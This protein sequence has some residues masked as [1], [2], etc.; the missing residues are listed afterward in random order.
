[1]RAW[2]VILIGCIAPEPLP[3][4]APAEPVYDTGCDRAYEM[5]P[6]DPAFIEA[7]LIA[8]PGPCI[9]KLNDPLMGPRCQSL[10]EK[11]LSGY[12]GEPTRLEALRVLGKP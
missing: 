9:E 10:L 11:S 1:M 5:N 12:F 6:P 4:E 3:D 2:L 7:Q 8:I